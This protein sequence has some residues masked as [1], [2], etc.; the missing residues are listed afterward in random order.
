MQPIPVIDLHADTYMKHLALRRIPE[1]KRTYF[2]TDAD[3]R[4]V[5]E[6]FHITPRALME[7]GVAVQTQSLFLD[8]VFLAMPLHAAMQT[9][10]LMLR[11]IRRYDQLYHVKNSREIDLTGQRCGLFIS[12]EGLE[13]IESDLDLLDVFY[14]LGVRLV[15]PSWNRPLPWAG[16]VTTEH[17]LLPA[18]HD[19]LARMQELN[20]I[21]DISHLSTRSSFDIATHFDGPIIASHS[22]PAAL[23]NHQRN[24]SDDQL[25]MLSERNGIFGINFCPAFLPDCGNDAHGFEQI[26]RVVDYTLQHFGDSIIAIGSDFDGIATTPR[27]VDGP[28]IFPQLATYLK[29]RGIGRASIENLFFRNALRV[30][31]TVM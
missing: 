1:L 18:G 23:C 30:I 8:D 22:N 2:R 12:I 9:V 24:L 15:A 20:M 16:A 10:S 31:Q 14:Q 13:V 11:D 6:S 21:V 3:Y 19:L 5:A 28:Q 29:D 25:L 27:G 7:G 4:P 26:Y 17:G